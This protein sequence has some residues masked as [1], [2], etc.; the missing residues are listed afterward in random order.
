VLGIKQEKNLDLGG[1]EGDI[2]REGASAGRPPLYTIPE[3]EQEGRWRSQK[4]SSIVIGLRSCI[5]FCKRT[6]CELGGK[7]AVANEYEPKQKQ[8]CGTSTL[9]QIKMTKFDSRSSFEI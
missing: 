6:I 4:Q 8:L 9:I 1:R 2:W 5:P 3:S 7:E